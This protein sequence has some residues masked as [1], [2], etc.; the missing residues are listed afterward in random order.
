FELCWDHQDHVS[1]KGA[2]LDLHVHKP[3]ST[4]DWYTT[5]DTCYWSNC[6]APRYTVNWGYPHTTP[7][8]LCA[9]S[10]YGSTWVM[11]GYC[12]NPRLDNDNVFDV[13][14]PENTNIDNPKDG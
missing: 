6:P 3:G 5:K 1:D 7:P 8:D 11:K 9:G 12:G 14:V 10:K 2:D 4:T 13:G